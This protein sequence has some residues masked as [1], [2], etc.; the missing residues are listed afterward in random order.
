M[1]QY[2]SYGE[3]CIALDLVKQ[4]RNAVLT[5]RDKHNKCTATLKNGTG[6]SV[7]RNDRQLSI[8]TLGTLVDDSCGSLLS[9][10]PN[11]S[12]ASQKLLQGYWSENNWTFYKSENTSI[13][14]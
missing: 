6:S 4:W 12:T 7:D 13:V 14:T 2:L 3:K 8:D 5:T 1:T 10:G 11:I 9:K